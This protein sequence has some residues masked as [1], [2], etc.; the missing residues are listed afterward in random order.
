MP[1]PKDQILDEEEVYIDLDLEEEEEEEIDDEEETPWEDDEEEEE[2]EWEDDPKDRKTVSIE[3]YKQLQREAT[4]GVKKVLDQNKM[5]KETFRLLPEIA[6]NQEK[7]LEVYEKNPDQAQ[8]ILENYYWGIS[9]EEFAQQELWRTYK[10]S[11]SKT[12]EQIR[13]EE[14]QKIREEQINT[15][16]QKLIK[17]AWLSEKQEAKLMEE[18]EELTEGKKLTQ[19][20]AQ[21]YFQIAYDLVR[22]TP[23]DDPQTAQIKKTAPGWGAPSTKTK[24]KEDP[25]VAEAKKF[26]QE[27]GQY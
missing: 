12:E 8:L 11:Q 6:D 17:K 25:Y 22:K 13:E 23:K 1:T 9:I 15:H 3:E 5:L 19:E 10:A 18:Y 14:R 4:K 21:K 16:I 26:L 24:G 2:E 20:K 27:H 7:L